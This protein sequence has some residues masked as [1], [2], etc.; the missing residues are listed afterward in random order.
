M[1]LELREDKEY[2][3]YTDEYHLSSK[4]LQID[5]LIIKKVQGVELKNEIGKLFRRHNL[6]EY[7]SPEDAL[8]IDTF[9]KVIGY[10]CI[11]KANEKQ[12]DEIPLNE[13]T[14]TLIREKYPRKLFQWFQEL[15][16]C[17]Y[18][19]F[20][21]IFYVEQKNQFPIQ[22]VVSEMLEKED[23]QWLTLLNRELKEEDVRR[24]VSQTND[25]IQKDEKDYADAVL[26]IA[27]KENKQTFYELR[28]EEVD[29]CEALRE[30]MED[31]IQAEIAAAEEKVKR[32]LILNAL[33]GG[34]SAEEVAEFIKL[35]LEEVEAVEKE[36]LQTV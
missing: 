36:A 27:I 32:E 12:V 20:S 10:A 35:P 2:L 17:V 11:Y 18:E 16:Y 33:S 14:I 7:K 34:R 13:I 9:I 21:G 24:A 22:V 6:I 29:M 4:P 31:V 30:L 23:Q 25:L 19:K 1:K 5:L 3:E 28:E 26:Q 15:G 8:S